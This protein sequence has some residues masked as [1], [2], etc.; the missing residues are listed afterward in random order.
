M[1]KFFLRW[2][3]NVIGIYIAVLI[4]PGIDFTGEWTGF[5][6]LAL[7]MGLLNALVR[8]LLKLLTCPLIVLT[9]G[10]F[11]LLINTFIFM[12]TTNIGQS[13]GIGV[14]VDGFWSAFLGG[15]VVSV[16]SIVLTLI[17]KDELKGRK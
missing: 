1:T 13:F 10:L 9:L 11:T 2:A 4:V 14:A 8:P 12:L 6:W 16:V 17:L 7:I 3:I 5:L 15:L